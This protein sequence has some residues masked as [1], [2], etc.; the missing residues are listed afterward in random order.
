MSPVSDDPANSTP[1]TFSADIRP[2]FR[3]SDREAMHK[4]FDLWDYDNV[5]SHVAAISDKLHEGTMPCDGAWSAEKV[6]L[7]DRWRAQGAPE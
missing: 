6:S 1:V 2:L 3:A 5:V 4:A 7:F